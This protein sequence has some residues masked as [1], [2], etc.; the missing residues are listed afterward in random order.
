MLGYFK[1]GAWADQTRFEMAGTY[2]RYRHDDQAAI[3]VT[4][5]RAKHFAKIAGEM[6]S[7]R[8]RSNFLRGSLPSH[9]HA[10]IAQPGQPQRGRAGVILVTEDP[11]LQRAQYAEAAGA[12]GIAETVFPRDFVY[13]EKL[14]VLPTGKMDYA[15]IEQRIH[16]IAPNW[17]WPDLSLM[18]LAGCK[19]SPSDLCFGS[20]CL[21]TAMKGC[22]C[23][24]GAG[25]QFS[26]RPT[27]DSDSLPRSDREHR[28]EASDRCATPQASAKARGDRAKT[29]SPA[30]DCV[31]AVPPLITEKYDRD[32]CG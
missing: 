3:C 18:R 7:L 5:G 8:P 17:P 11:H 14:P 13:I 32:R 29:R 23:L 2:G 26:R 20:F 24:T 19:H 9:K 10:A 31:S 21:R 25:V 15:A 12:A 30:S 22:R 1:H 6:V 28:A 27:S 16:A 4:R